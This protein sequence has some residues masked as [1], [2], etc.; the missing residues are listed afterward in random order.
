MPDLSHKATEKPVHASAPGPGKH[1]PTLWRVSAGRLVRVVATNGDVIC[2]VHRVGRFQEGRSEASI[3]AETIAK[4]HLLAAAPKMLAAGR[5]VLAG[6][7]A[8]I[9]GADLSSV[10]VFDGI[11]DLHAAISAANGEGE[12]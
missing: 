1:A 11:A 4:A 10:P 7:N 12:V 8:R 3:E 5:K 2:G 9:D 6:L